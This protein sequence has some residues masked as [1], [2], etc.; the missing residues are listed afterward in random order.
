MSHLNYPDLAGVWNYKIINLRRTNPITKPSFSNIIETQYNIVVEQQNQFII[1]TVPPNPPSRLIEGY[2]L[3]LINQVYNNIDNF[4]QLTI[5]DF[6]DTGV[7]N[8]TIKE[9]ETECV[10][11][12]DCDCVHDLSSVQ[13]R[14]IRPTVLEGYYVESGFSAINP[15]QNQAIAQITWTR[16]N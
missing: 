1:E 4:W 9:Y 14:R 3:G 5:A 11:D 16:I 10:C 7:V 12:S 8:L 2:Q 13:K 6:D 15:D